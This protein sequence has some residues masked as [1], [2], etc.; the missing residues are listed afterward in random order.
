ME[1][2]LKALKLRLNKT[3]KSI[4]ELEKRKHSSDKDTKL[5][6]EKK[7]KKQ[8]KKQSRLSNRIEKLQSIIK[9]QP[10]PFK[11]PL[12]LSSKKL[13]LLK[14]LKKEHKKLKAEKL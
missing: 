13:Q 11:K 5:V 8:K 12:N 9:T 2:R 14:K 4:K 7:L 1:V 6:L 3:N 10:K